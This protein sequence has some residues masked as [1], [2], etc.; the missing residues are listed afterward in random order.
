MISPGTEVFLSPDGP[1]NEPLC[2][3]SIRGLDGGVCM[4]GLTG[5]GLQPRA[6]QPV[7]MYYEQDG[8]FTRQTAIVVAAEGSVVQLRLNGVAVRAERRRVQRVCYLEVLR[9]VVEEPLVM[10]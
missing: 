6:G 3:G 5:R 9:Q 2:R 4:V 8:E 1:F 7:S 10:R